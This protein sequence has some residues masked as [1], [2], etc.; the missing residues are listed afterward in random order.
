MHIAQRKI[1]VETAEIVGWPLPRRTPEDATNAAGSHPATRGRLAIGPLSHDSAARTVLAAVARDFEVDESQ[2]LSTE[3][4]TAPVA[5]ARQ[6]A[7]YLLHVELGRQ[8]SEVGRLLGRDRTTVSH[9]C[10][11]VEDLRENARFDGRIDG[12]EL[13]IRAQ[14]QPVG[15]NAGGADV[16]I[17]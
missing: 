12:I 17:A 3:R 16:D 14:S 4:C 5:L 1:G 10:A 15:R 9:A 2:L 8:L 6:V 13:A 7:M 11:H